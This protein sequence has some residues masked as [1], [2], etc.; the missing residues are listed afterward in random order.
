MTTTTSS[1]DRFVCAP[2]CTDRDHHAPQAF[3]GDQSCWGPVRKTVF[4][5]EPHAPALPVPDEEIS[6]APGI[7]VYPYQGWYQLP[8]LKLHIFRE[9]ENDNTSVDV[10]FL[11]TPSE[12]IDLAFN[13]IAAVEELAEGGAR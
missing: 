11:I 6:E 1:Q 4:G 3:R 9:S 8:K 7:A 10:D 5:L 13:L 2:W 12:A